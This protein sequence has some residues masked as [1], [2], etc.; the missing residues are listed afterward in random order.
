MAGAGGTSAAAASPAPSGSTPIAGTD[1]ASIQ[2]VSGAP[3]D[4]LELVDGGTYRVIS[5]GDMFIS[6]SAGAQAATIDDLYIPAGTP[7]VVT[8]TGW[9][10]LN[11]IVGPMLPGGF[12]QALQIG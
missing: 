7:T 6:L 2:A 4:S 3:G 8:L 12:V 5:D 9:T 11:T 1:G 10:H